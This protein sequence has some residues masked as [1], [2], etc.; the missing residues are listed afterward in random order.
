MLKQDKACRPSFSIMSI[1]TLKL[2]VK[3]NIFTKSNTPLI[4]L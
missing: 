1:E 4:N 2:K 3:Q